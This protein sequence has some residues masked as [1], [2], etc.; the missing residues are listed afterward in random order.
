MEAVSVQ[1]R[2]IFGGKSE[3][4]DFGTVFVQIGQDGL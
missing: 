1:T 4:H 2:H 3:Q